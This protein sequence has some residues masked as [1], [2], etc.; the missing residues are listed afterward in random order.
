MYLNQPK[1]PIDI[2]PENQGKFTRWALSHGFKNAQQ[3]AKHVM[4]NK[5]KYTKEVVAMANFACN[6]KKWS[7]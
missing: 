2:K 5:S 7:N 3:A 1:S 6:S 4:A